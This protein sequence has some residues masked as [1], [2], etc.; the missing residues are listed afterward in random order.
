MDIYEV[1]GISKQSHWQYMQ[2]RKL[3]SEKEFM[4]INSILDVRSLHPSMGL[5][6][7]YY[8]LA[9]DWIGR[10]RFIEF[11]V[12]NGLEVKQVKN[13]ART[14]FSNKS[15]CFINLLAGLVIK[16]INIVWVSDITYFKIGQDFFY[17]TFIEDIYSR[18]ILGYHAGSDLRAEN[19]CKALEMAFK[20][21][22]GMDLSSLI[23]HSD[24]GTQYTSDKYLRMLLDRSIRVSMCGNVFENSHME[25]T[26]GIIKNEYLI[27]YKINSLK[28]L[29]Y[30]LQKAVNLYNDER[31]HWNLFRKPPLKYEQDLQSIGYEERQEMKIYTTDATIELQESMFL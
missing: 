11:G 8:L 3:D 25:R 14:T 17:I 22:N 18:R 27:H 21:R 28:D 12:S 1:S 16:D 2:R 15:A 4:A 6:K 7:I 23:H 24:K 26:N 10:D 5:K 29:R 30:Y 19:N 13:Y 9:P 31:P 20:N